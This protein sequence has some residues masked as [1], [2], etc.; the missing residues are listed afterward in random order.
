MK[1]AYLYMFLGFFAI[2]LA[3]V[4]LVNTNPQVDTWASILAGALLGFVIVK[5]PS[6]IAYI[7][8]SRNKSAK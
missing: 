5:S 2:I 3:V 6:I 8:S 4:L 1:K 7:K